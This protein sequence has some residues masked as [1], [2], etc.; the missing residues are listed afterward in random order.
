MAAANHCIVS[1]VP[2]VACRPAIVLPGQNNCKVVAVGAVGEELIVPVTATF[3]VV[4]FVEATV[5]LPVNVPADTL[6]AN[7]T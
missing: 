5:I 2:A 4:T 3:C 1:P 6:E 7:L